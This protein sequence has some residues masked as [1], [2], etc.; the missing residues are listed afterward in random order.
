MQESEPS[1]ATASQ[2]AIREVGS[3]ELYLTVF[4]TGAMVMTIEILGTRIIGPVFGVGLFVWSALL[5]VTLAALAVGYYAGGVLADR[6]LAATLLGS[7]V[8][9]AGLLLGLAPLLTR[10]VLSLA[11][12]LGPRGGALLAAALLF[13]PSL[14]ALGMTSTIAVRLATRT[15]A[16]AGRGIGSVYA[17]STGGSL[18]GTLVVGFIV[19]PAFDARSI[20]AGAAAILLLLGGSS[21]A[22]RK[23]PLALGLLLWP[24]L[25][26]SG[27]DE[28]LPTGFRVLDR[29]QSLLGLVEVI[30][31]EKRG[32]RFMRS[33]HS[34]LGAQFERDGSPGFGFI[35]VLEAVRF[36]RPDATSLLNIGLGTGAAP[37]ALGR[38]GLRVDVVEIDP[39]VVEL[40]QKHFGFSATG[41]VYVEDAR[42]FLRRTEQ[43]YDIIIH[44]T[45]TGGTTPEHLLSLEVLQRV[46]RVL[47]PGGVLVLN[48]V[49][50]RSGP[51]AE[52]SF[53]V[54]RTL[55]EVFREARAYADHAP[56]PT[57]PVG[58]V[59]FFAS[60]QSIDFTIP[61]DAQ[62][63]SSSAERIQRAFTSWSV[64][65]R[66]PAGAVITDARNPLARLQLPIAEKHFTA[67]NE[68]LPSDVWIR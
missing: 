5:A 64:L 27:P 63:E 33:D 62:F 21:L 3:A 26:G 31:D 16:R 54:A 12:G 11:E 36:A 7:V 38:Q 25:I 57:K 52:A 48:F 1:V 39:A 55:R 37:A 60:D 30:V 59:I 2:R 23:R 47:K 67:M 50:Y 45:F 10:I 6:K 29:S 66:V 32:V 41:K 13:A 49:G 20:L 65:E 40:A 53:A 61:A 44:D 46:H 4:I 14:T 8:L 19:V 35:H 58:N 24:L 34:I 18:V 15:L 68:L 43:R 42:A 22:I 9:S 28:Q 17:V 56:D 51:G